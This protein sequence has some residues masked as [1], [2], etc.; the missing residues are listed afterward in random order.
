MRIKHCNLHLLLAFFLLFTECSSSGKQ[1]QAPAGTPHIVPQIIRT[2]PHDNQA[3][4]QGLLY[5]NNEL[6][7]STGLVGKSSLRQIDINTGSVK[8]NI[9]I[10]GIFTE[11]LVLKDKVFT[12]LTWRSGYAFQYA[13]PSLKSIGHFKYNGEGWGL[14][15][16]GSYFIMSNGSDT[17]Y[18]R[19]SKF[20]IKKKVAVTY[21]GQRL[22]ML[23]E[24]EYARG[25]VYANVLYNNFIYEIDPKSGKV[26]RTIN[27]TSLVQKAGPIKDQDVLNGIAYNADKDIFYLT[28]KNWPVI[29]E[30]RIPK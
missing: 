25:K 3:F 10:P 29:F 12:Q 14:T 23:N 26:L 4:T 6:F 19:D 8:K 22:R 11:G 2:L 5:H 13:Y 15:S 18:F 24:L 16:D 17:L 30:V 27:C 20:T 21:N 7:E 1:N 28:G 9:P